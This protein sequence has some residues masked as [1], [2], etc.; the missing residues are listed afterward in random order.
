MRSLID[1]LPATVRR[2]LHL[3]AQRA[4]RG[5][6]SQAGQ[7]LPLFVIMSIAI[8]GGAA[9]LTDVA[10]WW[11]FEQ[12]AQR[13]ADAG[14]LAGA[15][16]LPGNQ[17]RAFSTAIA[18]AAKNGF[19][20]GTDGVVVTP[21]R[22]PANARK[23][24]VD[25]DGPVETHFAR[26]FC[27]N[28]DVCLDSVDVGVTGA[29]E[30]V[31]PVPMGSPQNYYGVGLLVD[32]VT[33][34]T[35]TTETRPT[36]WLPEAA[37]VSGAWSGPGNAIS[38]NNQYATTTANNAQHTWR[39]SLGIPDDPTVVI[40]GVQ[41][42]LTDAFLSGSATSCRINVEASWNGGAAGSWTTTL[43]QTGNLGTTSSTDYPFGS[44]TSASFGGHTW[45][46]LDFANFQVRLTRTGT[47][48]NCPTTRTVRL[49]MLEAR[50]DYTIDV[51][52]TSTTV[53]ETDVH[54][55][56]GEVL[57]PQNFWGALQTQGAPNIQ[58][59]A[60]MTYYDTRTGVTN[61]DYQ[62]DAFYQYAVE[63]PVGTSNGQ[64]WLF[65]PGFCNVDKE[66]GTGEYYTKGGGYGSSSFNPVSTFYDLWDTRNTPYD[67]T[68][69]SLVYSSDTAY[70]SKK[71]YDTQ[72]DL[73]SPET[74][75][76]PCDDLAWHNDWVQVAN[77][78]TGGRT[79]R[80]HTYS[81]DPDSPSDQ[82]DATTLNAFAVWSKANGGTPKV[83]GLGAMEA[84][85]RLPGGRATE[86]YLARIEERH[87]GKTMAIRLW[88]PGDTGSLAASL[89]I[90]GPTTSGYVVTPFSYTAEPNSGSASSCASRTGTNVT[91]VTTN[92]GGTSLFNG[93]WLN[94]ELV[95][96]N[97]YVAPH[98]S[99]DSVTSEGG[100]WKI[101]YNMSGSTGDY[102]TD[103]TTWQVELRGNPVHLV[104][105]Q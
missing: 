9:L 69:D 45:G 23:L 25:V 64:V 37:S 46:R 17:G 101:R 104:V 88:D 31:L 2:L 22:D 21:R 32:A 5:S 98:P 103:L 3:A 84:Y 28:G 51:T 4:E 14:A 38:N 52:T 105:E 16:Y 34:T 1:L 89:Q 63:F 99:S 49:D 66:T 58:G 67:T 93:C 6:R 87:A 42:R 39:F 29:A 8:L 75:A 13:A 44:A 80:L 19:V 56:D 40:T 73:S 59:D 78:L 68:D 35:T 65:D 94:I 26:V 72:L 50:V 76:T 70:R 85:V 95:L 15:I 18:E 60:Y 86:F 30:Y 33:T 71:W 47:S 27:W 90:L 79:Y 91:S 100:W 82:R 55:P 36:N 74:T 12:R 57:A 7:V 62:P 41:V 10:W 48:T 43:L 53:E 11:T 81:T 77:G 54:S 83:Y 20:N 102:S 24:I 92:T 97:D 61:N 96:P